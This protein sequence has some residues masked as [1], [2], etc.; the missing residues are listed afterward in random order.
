MVG[1]KQSINLK[2]NN[3]KDLGLVTTPS[4]TAEYIISK[5]T[6]I[7]KDEKVLEPCVGPGIFIK[8]LLEKGVNKSQIYTYD[9][10]PEYGS[11]ME[12]LNISFEVKD[13]LLSISPFSYNQ[14]DVIVGNPPYLNK[15]SSYVR[16][17]RDKLKKIYGRI[18]AHETY[19]MFIVNSIWRLKNGGRLGFI[20]SDSFLT[21]NTHTKLRKFILSTCKIK[22]I[23][24]AP[25]KLF[26]NQNVS[27]SP[28]IIILEK[29]S[30]RE[31]I[32]NRSENI[33]TIIPELEN[34]SEYQNSK[35]IYKIKQRR[36]HL[37][38]F[39]LFF[40]DVEEEVIEL[41]ENSSKLEEYIKGYIGMHTH[42]NLKYIAAVNGTNLAEIFKKRNEKAS[43]S[44][45][46]YKIISKE[47]LN[48]NKWKPYLKRGGSDQ[49]YRPIM[50]ALDWNPNSIPIY[51][52]PND[53]PFEKEG[54][55]ISGVS[56]RLAARYMPEGCYWDSNKAI[57]FIVK[58]EDISIEY[59]LGLLNSSLYNY[60]MNGII[61]N[62]NSIQIT[63]IHAL[64]FVKPDNGTKQK[65]EDLVKNILK[66]KKNDLNYNFINEQKEIDNLI[67]NF[68][69]KKFNFKQN[70][71]KKLDENFSI[72][73]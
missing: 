41:F 50:E 49:Y 58:D 27:T 34:E 65:V 60:L 10:N 25:R 6:P 8:K 43:E 26:D 20:T 38:P 12:S 15:S 39:K 48:S 68:Y 57:G 32:K 16:K 3:H 22:E 21:L 36:Y 70:L 47:E 14:F 5:V 4:K 67:F 30:G 69:R 13:Y 23:S 18:N 46:M 54:I 2:L 9:I 17:Y 64:P 1:N 19:S 72:Y 40:T 56:S 66:H 42:N 7:Q 52:I 31:N 11:I 59:A 29:C 71:K 35:R 37:L 45:K 63:G 61:N 62:T 24:L 51:D 33:M 44:T 73:I 28:V 55:V 53:L